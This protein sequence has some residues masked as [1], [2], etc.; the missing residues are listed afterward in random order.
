[1]NGLRFKV[2]ELAVLAVSAKY[3]GKIVEILAVGPYRAGQIYDIGLKQPMRCIQ[4]ADYVIDQR[5]GKWITVQ[6][7]RLRKLDPPAEP[8]T[9][10]V[11]E[12]V[13]V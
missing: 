13:E 3:L 7:W 8:K 9:M 5:D 11:A 2:G 12:E 10:T 6:D 1:M 4:N